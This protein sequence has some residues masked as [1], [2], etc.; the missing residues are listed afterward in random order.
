MQDGKMMK[1]RKIIIGSLWCKNNF[2]LQP[3]MKS[4]IKDDACAKAH[5]RCSQYLRKITIATSL[6]YRGAVAA[7]AI[8]ITTI[9]RGVLKGNL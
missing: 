2:F 3:R 6:G 1:Y 5:T 9:L 4:T 8:A 7:I